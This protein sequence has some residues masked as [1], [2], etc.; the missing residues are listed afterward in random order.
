M[1]TTVITNQIEMELF[2]LFI[3]WYQDLEKC[4]LYIKLQKFILLA[5]GYIL[6]L[7]RILRPVTNCSEGA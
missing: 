1:E 4:S 3:N 6:F 7:K 2:S 5:L